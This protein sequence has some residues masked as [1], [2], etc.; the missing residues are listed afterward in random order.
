MKHLYTSVLCG[1]DR[2]KCQL[3]ELSGYLENY[4]WPFYFSD[5]SNVHT[6]SV[7]LLVNEKLAQD[8]AAFVTLARNEGKFHALVSKLLDLFLS[9]K[10]DN[11]LTPGFLRFVLGAFRNLEHESIK[12]CTLRYVS[13]PVWSHISTMR[14]NREL[15]IN[16]TIASNWQKYSYQQKAMQKKFLENS[17]SAS[18]G[19]SSKS[20]KRKRGTDAAAAEDKS[21][22]IQSIV[23][24]MDR[25]A[26]FI[27]V[28]LQ[29]TLNDLNQV[30]P[31]SL[32]LS[33]VEHKLELV[34][35]LLTQVHTRRYLT[36]LLDDMHFVLRCRRA[37]LIQS[38]NIDFKKLK[39]L[40][41]QVDDYL[42]FELDDLT[43]QALTNQ[44]LMER[45]NS[46]ISQLQQLAFADYSE[47]L[48][49]LMFSSL[50]E[51]VKHTEL[52]RHFA[53]LGKDELL[54][55]AKKLAVYNDNDEK[56]YGIQAE[57]IEEEFIKDLIFDYLSVR[58][59][60]M[61]RINKLPLYPTETLLWDD[62]FL[63]SR[64]FHDHEQAS[65]LPKLN[66]QYLTIYDC[67]MRNFLLYL[68]ESAYEIRG[69]LMDAIKRMGP[70]QLPMV[71]SINFAGWARMALPILSTTLDEVA[72]PFL[73]E[74]IPRSVDCT[75]NVR[76]VF[77][78]ID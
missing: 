6:F 29:T 65:A 74:I 15:S 56:L 70:R 35:E 41:D 28:I 25:D 44:D 69:D 12:N 1:D 20:S 7:L 14:L 58:S 45:C 42:R 38:T 55:I 36:T 43:G 17:S 19:Q 75:I 50:G 27:F 61:E 40:L 4:L 48:R 66:L 46:R 9:D 54:S 51:L 67:F 53:V 52:S 76:T 62:D 39:K 72:K 33:C 77:Y 2:L 23:Q 10:L 59:L 32:Q 49:G 16:E 64:A 34:V 30:S 24:S 13:L 71:T 3:L 57:L 22:Q 47:K 26:N 60:L 18:D 63:P 73:G 21:K 78:V 31:S 37:N 5:S 11:Q 8:S 68:M